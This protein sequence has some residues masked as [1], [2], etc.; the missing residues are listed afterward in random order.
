MFR[1]PSSMTAAV[2]SSGRDILLKAGPSHGS[3]PCSSLCAS[4]GFTSVDTM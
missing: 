3:W 1:I 4:T 2:S